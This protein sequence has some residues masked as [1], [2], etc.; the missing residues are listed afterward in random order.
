MRLPRRVYRMRSLLILVALL[1]VA[2]G[3]IRWMERRAS[4]FRRLALDYR[5]SA[6]M[7][8]IAFAV[9]NQHFGPFAVYQRKLQRKYEYAAAHPW[10]PVR[11][12]P[13][14]P[15]LPGVGV[16]VEAMGCGLPPTVVNYGGRGELVTNARGMCLTT[17]PRLT[18]LLSV[19]PSDGTTS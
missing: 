5:D 17:S 7:G 18:V 15:W 13:P 2:W 9:G 8:E 19:T 12:D 14:P 16:V 11:P 6:K 1:A 10:L 3:V 4:D